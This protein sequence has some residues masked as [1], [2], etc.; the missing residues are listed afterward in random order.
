MFCFVLC[1]RYINSK[2][3]VCQCLIIFNSD[4]I[5]QMKT[6]LIIQLSSDK[7]NI[8]GI[9][10][11]LVINKL[12]KANPTLLKIVSNWSFTSFANSRFWNLRTQ[13]LFHF[14]VSLM[15][16][17]WESSFNSKY[18]PSEMI[19]FINVSKTSTRLVGSD[20]WCSYCTDVSLSALLVNQLISIQ[21]M[22]ESV[23]SLNI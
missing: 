22:T 14:Q 16:S 18:F 13:D 1:F 11:Q 6:L 23:F 3:N 15:K 20:V 5:I 17:H 10:F 7:V 19:S 12:K 21:M 8:A 9:S 4:N 2:Q